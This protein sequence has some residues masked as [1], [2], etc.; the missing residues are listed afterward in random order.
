MSSAGWQSLEESELS[1][2]KSP[3]YTHL[4]SSS[5]LTR[6]LKASDALAW[7][8]NISQCACCTDTVQTQCYFGQSQSVF[9]PVVGSD[10]CCLLRFCLPVSW[11]TAQYKQQEQICVVVSDSLFGQHSINVALHPHT[12]KGLRVCPLK[13]TPNLPNSQWSWVT[14]IAEADRKR[15]IELTPHL[16]LTTH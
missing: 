16:I 12:C 7:V 11:Q 10:F 8:L 2:C 1:S 15:H 6:M 9:I 5:C 14:V 3:V 13:V 4:P